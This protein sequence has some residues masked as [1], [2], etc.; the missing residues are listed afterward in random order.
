MDKRIGIV[1]GVEPTV[2][3]VTGRY[4]LGQHAVTIAIDN[5]HYVRVLSNDYY[6]WDDV[7]R[8]EIE[9]LIKPVKAIEIK[10]KED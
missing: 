5:T 7:K 2:C 9:A 4:V 3:A 10:K 8:A 6:L 1:G